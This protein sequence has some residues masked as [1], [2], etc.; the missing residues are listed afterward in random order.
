MRKPSPAMIIALLSL[1]V[2]LGGAGMAA[3]GGNFILGKPNS[4]TSTTSL[5]AAIG[6]KALQL[7][8][9]S[10]TAGASALGLNVASGHPPFAVNSGVEVANLNADAL[11]G[12]DSSGFVKGRGTALA[13]RIVFVPTNTKTLLTIPGLGY[14]RA[15]CG[16]SD[17]GILWINT[18]GGNVDAW[19]D[20]FNS[21]FSGLVI[22]PNTA[23]TVALRSLDAYGGTLAL[24]VG[25]DPNPRRTAL[26]HAFAYQGGN[27]APCGF[28]VQG[29]L[30]TSP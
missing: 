28:Q 3:T 17:A 18:T 7:S 10:T 9:T 14:L 13:N 16:S 27:G 1:F 15:D 19:R 2:A 12:I 4:A 5:S 25:N 26:L 22:A 24:G 11:D 23:L 8:N 6:G 29:T 30:W 21:H 20:T